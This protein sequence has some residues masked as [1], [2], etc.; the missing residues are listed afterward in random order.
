MWERAFYAA[1]GVK[2]LLAQAK[3]RNSQAKGT[4]SGHNSGKFII[5]KT[6]KEQSV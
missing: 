5:L 3:D 4:V 1:E 6:P 2:S